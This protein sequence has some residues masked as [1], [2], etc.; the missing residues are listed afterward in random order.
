MASLPCAPTSTTSSPGTGGVATSV[1]STMVMSMVTRPTMRTRTADGASFGKAARARDARLP[2]H[3]GCHV[4]RAGCS[5]G[6]EPVR[7]QSGPDDAHARFHD[8]VDRRRVGAV[9]NTGIDATRAQF[10]DEREKAQDLRAGELGIGVGNRK[11]CVHCLLYTSDAA[12][13][14][15]S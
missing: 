13:E 5:V 10:V 4:H 2:A 15:S 3:D 1:R 9:N 14:R 12:D 8:G 11:V 6:V 7:Q